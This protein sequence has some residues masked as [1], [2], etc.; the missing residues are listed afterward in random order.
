MRHETKKEQITKKIDKIEQ[1]EKKNLGKKKGKSKFAFCKYWLIV[2]FR[3][4]SIDSK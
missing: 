4:F 2:L 1:N 3:F